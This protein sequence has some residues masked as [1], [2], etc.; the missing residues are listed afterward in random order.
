MLQQL[1]V[2]AANM[3]YCVHTLH[4]PPAAQIEAVCDWTR[5]QLPIFTDLLHL[6]YIMQCI[7]ICPGILVLHAFG[8]LNL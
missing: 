7:H 1:H 3:T 4:P 8:I 2:G 6:T 5:S